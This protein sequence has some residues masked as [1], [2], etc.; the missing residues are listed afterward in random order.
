[1]SQ[2]RRHHWEKRYATRTAD[3]GGLDATPVPAAGRDAPSPFV[4]AHAERLRGRVLD[5][6]GGAGRNALHLARR[7]SIIEIIDVA[8]GG[9]KLARAAAVAAG[10]EVLA[11]QADLETFPLPVE[12]YD[13][14]MNI[15]YLQRSL[16][17]SLQSAVKPGGVILFETFLIDQQA[18]GHPK[19]PDFLLK[20]GELRSAFR[21]CDI[22]VYEEGLFADGDTPAY[23]ARMLARRHGGIEFSRSV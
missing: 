9:L 16:F 10:V 15:R 5:V 2:D 8:F 23:L 1:M 3:A 19:N 17:R 21:D 22:L 14:V 11:V 12:R 18:F 4:V 13:G 7:G 6:A 20:H